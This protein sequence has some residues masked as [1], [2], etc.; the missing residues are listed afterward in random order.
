[1]TKTVKKMSDLT[2]SESAALNVAAGK[3]GIP[4]AWLFGLIMTES[5][6]NPTIKNPLGSARGLIQWVDAT[7]RGMGYLSAADLVAK[8]PTRESQ[9]LGPVVAYLKQ[10]API[11]SPE[12]L[13]AV[14]FYPKNR[15]GRIDLPLPANVQKQNPGIVTVRD[16]YKKFLQKN[17][18]SYAAPL[19]ALLL[20]SVIFF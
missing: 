13:A 12:D 7:A 9:L 11:T 1:M 4:P 10:W 14:N 2:P 5:R 8:H 3:I 6:W 20:G 16:Y 19:A 18:P 17:I 15:G